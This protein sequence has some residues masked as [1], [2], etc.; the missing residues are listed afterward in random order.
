[1][2]DDLYQYFK[3]SLTAKEDRVVRNPREYVRVTIKQQH[4]QLQDIDYVLRLL[5]YRLQCVAKCGLDLWKFTD[6]INSEWHKLSAWQT[7]K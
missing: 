3:C 7:D 6:G 5:S 4:Y 1:M 2:W